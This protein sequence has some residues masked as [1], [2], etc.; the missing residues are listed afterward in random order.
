MAMDRVVLKALVNQLKKLVFELESEIYSDEQVY[1]TPSTKS[2]YN[3]ISDND[4]DGYPD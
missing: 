3:V 1:V 4:D 2:N